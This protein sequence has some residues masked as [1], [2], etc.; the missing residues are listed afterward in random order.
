MLGIGCSEEFLGFIIIFKELINNEVMIIELIW[1]VLREF[2]I[3][4]I[5]FWDNY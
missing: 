4:N 1:G 2:F 3:D 5:G